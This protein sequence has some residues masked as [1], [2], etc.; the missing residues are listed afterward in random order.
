MSLIEWWMDCCGLGEKERIR[1]EESCKPIW[2]IRFI[3]EWTTEFHSQISCPEILSWQTLLLTLTTCAGTHGEPL[4]N[5]KSLVAR[6]PSESQGEDNSHLDPSHKT[7]SAKTQKGKKKSMLRSNS[8]DDFRDMVI[9]SEGKI[10]STSEMRCKKRVL[11]RGLVLGDY[12]LL[13]E[14]RRWLRLRMRTGWV[15]RRKGHVPS[16]IALVARTAIISIAGAVRID[17]HW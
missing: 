16:P 12:S 11:V 10:R 15:G 6:R 14:L 8:N 5:D 13:M 3:V 2:L 9:D 1:R 4:V 17:G 7:P